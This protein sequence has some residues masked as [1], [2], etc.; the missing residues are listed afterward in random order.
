MENKVPKELEEIQKKYI[1]TTRQLNQVSM[2]KQVFEQEYI[3]EKTALSYLEKVPEETT[4]YRTVGRLFIKTPAKE[5]I[6]NYSK[7]IDF[8]AIEVEKN[9]KAQEQLTEKLLQLENEAK[10]ITKN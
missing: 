4:S 8:C 6:E 5:L 10:K 9:K 2:A 7:N 3:R 1:S